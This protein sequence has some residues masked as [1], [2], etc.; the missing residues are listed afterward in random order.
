MRIKVRMAAFGGL[1]LSFLRGW[2]LFYNHDHA[3]FMK[4]SR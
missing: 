3:L 2:M 4:R 1:L